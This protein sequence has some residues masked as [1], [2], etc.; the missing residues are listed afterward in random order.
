VD[1]PFTLTV[2]GST[3]TIQWPVTAQDDRLT[4]NRRPVLLAIVALAAPER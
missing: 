1:G 3:Y 4:R 2:F